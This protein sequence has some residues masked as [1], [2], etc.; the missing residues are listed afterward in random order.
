MAVKK[1]TKLYQASLIVF[2]FSYLKV[3][4]QGGDNIV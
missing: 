3:E 4:V 2:Y 1:F